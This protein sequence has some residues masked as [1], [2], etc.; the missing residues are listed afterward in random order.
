MKFWIKEFVGE[1]KWYVKR[2][3]FQSIFII[4]LFSILLGFFIGKNIKKTNS[5][6]VTIEH[7]DYKFVVGIFTLLDKFEKRVNIDKW[8]ILAQI[9]HETDYGKSRV[10]KE[11]NNLLGIRRNG[12]YVKYNNYYDCLQD[13]YTIVAF[14]GNKNYRKALK[15]SYS[16]DYVNFYKYLQKGGYAKDKNYAVKC[17]NVYKNIKK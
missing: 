2:Y 5:D 4:I 7:S 10:A 14:S 13:Y 15:C 17:I 11:N 1:I 6:M 9:C 12:A 8:L 16:G 3:M